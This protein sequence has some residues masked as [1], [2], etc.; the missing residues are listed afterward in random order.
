VIVWIDAQL[1]PALAPW[2][3]ERFNVAAF[4]VQHLG[5][6]DATDAQIFEAARAAGA[7]V[8]TNDSDLL[9][10]LEQHGPPPQVLWV[11]LATRQT[12]GC[13]KCWN[14]PS[15]EPLRCSQ[16]ARWSLS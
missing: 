8:L 7:V 9:R 13:E 1:S 6:R 10:L 15:C 4:S 16:V 2:L 14:E 11:T 3:S 12:R 5:Y